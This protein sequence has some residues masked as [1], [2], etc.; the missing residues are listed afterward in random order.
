MSSSQG[1]FYKPQI[2]K[3]LKRWNGKAEI[4][5]NKQELGKF[6]NCGWKI[7]LTIIKVVLTINF[8]YHRLI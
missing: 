5:H 4:P 3:K 2:F 7:N 8:F 1:V 6:D